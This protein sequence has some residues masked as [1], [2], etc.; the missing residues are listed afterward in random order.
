MFPI[1]RSPFH[2]TSMLPSVAVL[3]LLLVARGVAHNYVVTTTNDAGVHSL[4]WAI[5]QAN[6]TPGPDIITFNIPGDGPHSIVPGSALPALTD[7]AG[8]IIDGLSQPGTVI[9]MN[10]PSTLRLNIQLDGMLD[11]DTPGLL[12]QSSF[13][14]IQGVAIG[15]FSREGIR[16]EGF[17]A[18]VRGNTVRY[19][20]VGTLADGEYAAAN[21]HLARTIRPA[22]IA[23]VSDA[24][25]SGSIEQTTI[26][27][28]VISGN[29][30][31]GMLLYAAAGII[32][33]CVIR[34]N[35]IGASS[36]GR[37]A[38]AN[39][40]SGVLI[41]GSALHNEISH[42]LIAANEQHGIHLAGFADAKLTVRE[43]SITHNKIGIGE[44]FTPLGN[45]M[46]GISIGSPNHTLMKGGFASANMVSGNIISRNGRNGITI[47]EHPVDKVNAD[48][49]RLSSNSMCG[50]AGLGIDLNDDG[51]DESEL[52]TGTA[53]DGMH[54]PVITSAEFRDGSVYLHGRMSGASAAQTV[55]IEIFRCNASKAPRRTGSLFIGS[56]PA[57]AD[58]QW[59][60]ATTGTLVEGDSITA[61]ATDARGNT[62]ELGQP[63]RV[64]EG[65]IIA[66][67][68]SSVRPA[69][70]STSAST[71]PV[72]IVEIAPN[73]VH[74][75]ALITLN[76]EKDVWTVV[77]VY[78]STGMLVDKI[79]DCWTPRG[80]H[81]LKW[82]GNNW[83]GERVEPGMYVC[84]ADANGKR[85]QRQF[86]VSDVSLT[87]R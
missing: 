84:V 80:E 3:L 22:G 5:Q 77:E 4:R 46:D 71:A 53:N 21:G 79:Y 48:G 58:G 49:N 55:S 14:T 66:S 64:T 27:G 37:A 13:N 43:T 23:L 78:S 35:T 20:F 72:S 51:R 16:I 24:E 57:N 70:A 73:P 10:P 62:S 6:A 8:V 15:R 18:G 28:C 36:N 50:N 30:G 2:F 63:Y 41:A 40:G 54:A 17:G 81:Q 75:Q 83:K 7:P 34:G 39:H 11:G 9:G 1:P 25:C 33:R 86:E 56:V 82:N 61:T 69:F 74:E 65:A 31:E 32:Q 76:A 45:G 60:F 47:W 68:T 42:N 67:S 19:C 44:D 38:L 26:N 59:A 87:V 52:R 12:V 85:T 29:A